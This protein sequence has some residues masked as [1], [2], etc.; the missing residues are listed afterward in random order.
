MLIETTDGP[1]PSDRKT[2]VIVGGIRYPV[3]QIS[4]EELRNDVLA[5]AAGLAGRRPFTPEFGCEPLF[6]VEFVDGAFMAY[7][8]RP[9]FRGEWQGWLGSIKMTSKPEKLDDAVAYLE[10]YAATL[11][12]L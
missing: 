2:A 1:W 4:A 7:T 10:D 5:F 9:R 8:W 12:A 11:K 3:G 6:N